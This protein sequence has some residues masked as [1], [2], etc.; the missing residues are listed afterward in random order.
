MF[1]FLWLVTIYSSS[2]PCLL[3][4][5]HSLPFS[6]LCP[7]V[8]CTSPSLQCYS[9]LFHLSI[10]GLF[11]VFCFV[12]WFCQKTAPIIPMPIKY[13]LDFPIQQVNTPYSSE[14]NYGSIEIPAI[15]QNLNM[16]VSSFNFFLLKKKYSIWF[17]W[18]LSLAS[19]L[20][21]IFVC[22]HCTVISL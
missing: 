5:L 16:R 6:P 13:I 10:S 4:R 15:L 14:E 9:G 12:S 17:S 1:D 22:S 3:C 11:L 18:L 20:E 7:A 8:W 2:L 21:Y 19:Y